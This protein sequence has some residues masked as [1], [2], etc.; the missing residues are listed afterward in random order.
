MQGPGRGTTLAEWLAWLET[1]HP[2]KIDLS[3]NRIRAVLEE[4]GLEDPPY[5]IVVRT[6]KAPA[7]LTCPTY[8]REPVIRPVHSRPRT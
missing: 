3:L 5:R 7:S 8:I 2:K 4:L 6:A 1:L